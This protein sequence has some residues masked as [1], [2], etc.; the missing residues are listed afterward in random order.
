MKYVFFLIIKN[1]SALLHRSVTCVLNIDVGGR[2]TEKEN[3]MTYFEEE[4]FDIDRAVHYDD[5]DNDMY[6][7]VRSGTLDE[8]N[9]VYDV[10]VYYY[11]DN[12]F[13]LDDDITDDD[14]AQALAKALAA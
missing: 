8:T 14:I 1:L 12:G 4:K 10:R 3:I 2:P 11:N 7:A 6:N 5:L 13:I 9:S